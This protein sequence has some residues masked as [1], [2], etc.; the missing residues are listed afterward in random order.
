MKAIV[1]LATLGLASAYARH[2]IVEYINS[3]PST[4]RAGHNSRFDGMTLDQ[5]KH[6]MGTHIN[7][8]NSKHTTF[9]ASLKEGIPSSF[10][11]R[12]QW[13]RCKSIQMVR[14]QGQCGSC[15][16]FGAAE[17]FSDRYCIASGQKAQHVFSPYALMTCSSMNMGC[18][19]GRLSA[20]WDYIKDWGLPLDE[21]QPY[22]GVNGSGTP[23]CQWGK[24]LGDGSWNTWKVSSTSDPGCGYFSCSPSEMAE[25]IMKEG[26]IEGSFT[27]YED[28]MHYTG[29]VYQHKTG[30]QL[31]GHAIKIIGW[32]VEDGTPYWLCT[33]SWGPTW[34]EKGFF[35]ILRG[36]NECNIEHDNGAGTPVV[37][38]DL[39]A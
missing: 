26:P 17:S 21:C 22:V 4:W 18:N 2:D 11:S 5:V 37:K 12:E 16:A 32:G 30:S 13:P 15:W 36:S 10:D 29:G 20:A 35:K 34:G 1:V 25:A 6:L 31:G 28:F 23:A 39:F 14:D 24:C 3:M 38:D 27:V 33:N 9:G 7:T 8:T 19:G